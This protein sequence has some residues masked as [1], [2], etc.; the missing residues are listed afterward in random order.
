MR[1]PAPRLAP[2]R[3][4]YP[5]GMGQTDQRMAGYARP[6]LSRTSGSSASSLLVIGAG[7]RSPRARRLDACDAAGAQQPLRLR[8]E[9]VDVAAAKTD[10]KLAIGERSHRRPLHTPANIRCSLD[11]CEPGAIATRTGSCVH[12]QSVSD[13]S[14]AY[15]F[16]TAHQLH[17]STVFE[18]EYGSKVEDCGFFEHYTAP[19]G[20][21]SLDLKCTACPARFRA[22]A[23]GDQFTAALG[24]DSS[25]HN[26]R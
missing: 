14:S 3:N 18:H 24:R 5:V 12:P 23:G 10:Q 13:D 20:G 17:S 25:A 15:H 26:R 8:E 4:Y 22:G 2:L 16:E 7:A 11:E 21:W 1:T 9:E 19:S 6:K